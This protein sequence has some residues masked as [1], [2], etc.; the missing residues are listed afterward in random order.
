[1]PRRKCFLKPKPVWPKKKV[2]LESEIIPL[3]PI[4]YE[5]LLLP[6]YVYWIFAWNIWIK[7]FKNKPRK[8]C[9]RQSLTNLYVKFFKGYLSQIL[10]GPFLN[11]LT[12]FS[13]L[14]FDEKLQKKKVCSGKFRKFLLNKSTV[15]KAAGVQDQW[16]KE[17]YTGVS[18]D[19][20]WYFL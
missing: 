18:P 2:P 6:V 17:N 12:H 1:M 14:N 19:I 3:L 11:T 20:Q 13:F 16:K 10:L 15:I 8:I 5:I 4:L 7:V 9:R